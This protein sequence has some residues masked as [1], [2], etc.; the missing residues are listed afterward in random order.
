MVHRRGAHR[1]RLN[2]PNQQLEEKQ[3]W[4]SYPTSNA[5]RGGS[6]NRTEMKKAARGGLDVVFP[7]LGS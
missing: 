3:R 4:N 5:S 6:C 2:P 1:N 7:S